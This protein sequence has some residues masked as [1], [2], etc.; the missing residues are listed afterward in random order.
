MSCGKCPRKARGRISQKEGGRRGAGER[1]SVA[2]GT[3]QNI[4]VSGVFAYISL[5]FGKENFNY[6]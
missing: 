1:R 2:F 3:G 5:M 6:T 4:G